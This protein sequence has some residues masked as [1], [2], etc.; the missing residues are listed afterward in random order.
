MSFAHSYEN[1]ANT[2]FLARYVEK[3]FANDPF[4]EEILGSDR[5]STMETVIKTMGPL[6]IL[7][8]LTDGQKPV[9]S[10]LYDTQ[11]Y[12]RKQMEDTVLCGGE[13][14]LESKITTVFLRRWPEM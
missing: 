9:I 1:M 4:K 13:D 6:L 14:S 5:W 7:Y 10:N 3:N 2:I 11:L 12:V 8:R